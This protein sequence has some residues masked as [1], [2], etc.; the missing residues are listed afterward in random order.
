MSVKNEDAG[1]KLLTTF[2]EKAKGDPRINT[3]HISLYVSLIYY[4]EKQSFKNP[5]SFFSHD[6]KP[7]CKISGTATYCKSMHNLHDFGYLNYVP[8]YNHFKGSLIYFYVV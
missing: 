5:V 1:L 7:V 2:L 8:S 3:S 4:W 6:L